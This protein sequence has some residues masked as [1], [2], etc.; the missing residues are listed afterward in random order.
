MPSSPEATTRVNA[1]RTVAREGRK[2]LFCAHFANDGTVHHRKGQ[3][4][5][6]LRHQQARVS[7]AVMTE[8]RLCGATVPSRP[9][10]SWRRRAARCSR[11]AAS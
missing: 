4:L 1:N 3:G 11:Q 6:P 2:S 7:A 10:R 9:G 8:P 5:P